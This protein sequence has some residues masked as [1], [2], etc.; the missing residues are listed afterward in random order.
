[1]I[2]KNQRFYQQMEGK[3]KIRW[4]CTKR[5]CKA[6]YY[7]IGGVLTR[8]REKHDHQNYRPGDVPVNFGL[9]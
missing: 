6:F 7:T 4:R 2:Y 3:D 5:G 9:V 8:T 1:M